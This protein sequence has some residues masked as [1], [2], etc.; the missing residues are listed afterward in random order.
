[1][2]EIEMDKIKVEQGITQPGDPADPDAVAMQHAVAR[3]AQLGGTTPEGI[4]AELCA[5]ADAAHQWDFAGKECPSVIRAI[6]VRECPAN[7]KHY[8]DGEGGNSAGAASGRRSGKGRSRK[9]PR[10][11]V[12]VR[13]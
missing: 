6:R 7:G 12:P 13:V 5:K 8:Y 4:H 2:T 11:Q 10:S 9:A 1:M 3:A